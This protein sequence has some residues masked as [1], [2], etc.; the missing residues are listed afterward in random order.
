MMYIILY[1]NWTFKVCLIWRKFR[2]LPNEEELHDLLDYR[3][4]I[5]QPDIE[6]NIVDSYFTSTADTLNELNELNQGVSEQAAT[7]EQKDFIQKVLND[8]IEYH[9]SRS[10]IGQ[11]QRWIVNWTRQKTSSNGEKS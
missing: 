1:F 3:D 6:N 2:N 5:L 11:K 7:F 10:T 8:S 9:I 4:M